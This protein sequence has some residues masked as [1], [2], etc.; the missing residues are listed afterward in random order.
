M[1][2]RYFGGG[3]VVGYEAGFA[4]GPFNENPSLKNRETGEMYDC[5]GGIVET[6]DIATQQSTW[7]LVLEHNNDAHIQPAKGPRS[8]TDR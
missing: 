6:D 3:F 8:R 1:L 7:L 2:V 4:E 5:D